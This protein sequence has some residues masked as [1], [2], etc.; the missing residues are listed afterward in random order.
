MFAS[1]HIL[2]TQSKIHHIVYYTQAHI[3]IFTF[4]Q[5]SLCFFYVIIIIIIIAISG[6]I[7]LSMN[8]ILMYLRTKHVYVCIYRY[9]LMKHELKKTQTVDNNTQRKYK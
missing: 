1:I 5:L 2:Y 7:N 4:I 6:S 8:I 3:Y 9:E